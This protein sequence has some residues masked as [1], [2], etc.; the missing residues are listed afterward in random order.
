MPAGQVPNGDVVN[1][2]F[3]STVRVT[4]ELSGPETVARN[5]APT[6]LALQNNRNASP[7]SAF[8]T[9]FSYAALMNLNVKEHSKKSRSVFDAD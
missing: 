2:K 6:A 7:T 8:F 5:S 3:T 1:V 4:A 9:I